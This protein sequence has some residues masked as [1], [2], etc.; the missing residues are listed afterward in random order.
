MKQIQKQS[1]IIFEFIFKVVGLK[2]RKYFNVI[3]I[4]KMLKYSKYYKKGNKIDVLCY[5]YYSN[6][7]E[8]LIVGNSVIFKSINIGTEDL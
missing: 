3:N 7:L 8:V 2:Q 5:I 1:V 6:Q 4:V